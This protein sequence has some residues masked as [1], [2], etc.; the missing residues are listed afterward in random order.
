MRTLLAF[1]SAAGVLALAGPAAAGEPAAIVRVY[2]MDFSAAPAGKP[3]LDP[4]IRAGDTVRWV[5]ESGIHDTNSADGL[6]ESWKSPLHGTAGATFEHTFTHV[7]VFPY[8]CSLHGFDNGDG[9]VGGMSG[10]ITVV[11][12]P[13]F[14]GDGAL[15]VDDFVAFRAA[16][17]A[18]EDRADYDR[19]GELGV[20]DFAAF[21]EAYLAGCPS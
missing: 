11:C 7:G 17:L 12:G 16:Y 1:V 19:N 14:S 10:T 8:H 6:S 4:T 9:T 5:W 21:R 2:N 15:G 3:A 18:G 13:D 20:S